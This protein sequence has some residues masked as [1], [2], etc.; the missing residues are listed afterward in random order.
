MHDVWRKYNPRVRPFFLSAALIAITLNTGC[1]TT[2]TVY[3]SLSAGAEKV[4]TSGGNLLSSAERLWPGVTWTADYENAEQKA[5]ELGTGVLFLFTNHDR[6]KPDALRDHLKD[7]TQRGA[8]SAYIP[9]L[10]FKRNESDRRYADQFGVQ[11][12]PAIIVVHPDGSYHSTQGVLST[13]K[14]T[15]FLTQAVPPGTAPKLNPHIARRLG[16]YWHRDWA[17]AKKAAEDNQREMF[18]VLERWMSRDWDILEPMIERR[19]VYSRVAHMVHCRPG[20][21]WNSAGA[22]ATQ[23]GVQ[24]FPAIVIVPVSGDPRILELPT[25]YEAIVRFADQKAEPP[26]AAADKPEAAAEAPEAAAQKPET[27]AP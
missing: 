27:T 7:P 23:L 5:S 8:A 6:T 21:A 26:P 20:T 14:A 11:R 4:T 17:T 15:E 9:A 3:D 19:E 2:S 24:N 22:V 10:L 16:Y 1:S 12:A 25:S 13:E 18:V